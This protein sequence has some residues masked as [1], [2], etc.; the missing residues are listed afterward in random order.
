[1][2]MRDHTP[3]LRALIATDASDSVRLRHSQIQGIVSKPYSERELLQAV[4]QALMVSP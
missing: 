3:N 2:Q 4:R 1:M